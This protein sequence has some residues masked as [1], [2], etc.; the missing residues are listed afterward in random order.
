MSLSYPQQLNFPNFTKLEIEHQELIESVTQLHPPYSDFNFVSMWS[1]NVEDDLEFSFLNDNLILCFRDYITNQPFLTFIGNNDVV[2]TAD[3]LIAHAKKHNLHEELK[4]IPEHSLS[5][6]LTET[7]TIKED[8]DNHDYI[9]S[10]HDIQTLPGT[11]Y[12]SK[13][14]L[15]NK[16]MKRLDEGW[17]YETID[18]SDIK[19]QKQIIDVFNTWAKD[20]DKSPIETKHE[21]IALNR[22]LSHANNLDVHAIGIYFHDLLQGYIVYEIIHNDHA[23]FHFAKA[24]PQYKELF[25]VLMKL[26]ADA[27]PQQIQYINYEQDLGLMHLREAKRYWYPS[28]YL[29]KYI[30][31]TK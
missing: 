1:Y 29:K 4:L 19:I 23:I 26:A 22:L 12:Y 16:F 14:K 27:L 24:N 25:T 9:L 31:S 30:V 8:V 5:D 6:Q 17:K 18:I 28:H 7:F 2:D 10:A 11:R 21:Y 15:I 3:S 20:Y 13:R